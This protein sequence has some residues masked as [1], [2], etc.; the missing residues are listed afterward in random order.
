LWQKSLVIDA[1][2]LGG[3]A[4]ELSFGEIRILDNRT[5]HSELRTIYVPFITYGGNSNSVVTMWHSANR[6]GEAPAEP[7]ILFISVWL[8][9]YRSNGSEPFAFPEGQWTPTGLRINGGV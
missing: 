1:I 3:Q 2:C 5:P 7:S 6:E 9:W 4:T 8:D